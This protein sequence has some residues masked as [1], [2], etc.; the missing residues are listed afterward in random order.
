M[1]DLPEGV[2]FSAGQTG[3]SSKGQVA[4][5]RMT[6]IQ[7]ITPWRPLDHKDGKDRHTG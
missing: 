7:S 2:V 5:D 4:R 3:R 6:G 1:A